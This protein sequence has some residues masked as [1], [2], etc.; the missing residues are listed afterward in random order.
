MESSSINCI[1][2]VGVIRQHWQRTCLVLENGEGSGGGC[3]AY[4]GIVSKTYI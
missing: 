1:G 3:Y 2:S 4:E